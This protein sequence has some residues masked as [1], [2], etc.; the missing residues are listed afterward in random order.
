MSTCGPGSILVALTKPRVRRSRRVLTL[1]SLGIEIQR[2]VMSWR[3]CHYSPRSNHPGSENATF[4]MLTDSQVVGVSRN[5]LCLSQWFPT[6]WIG[7]SL[8]QNTNYSRTWT[9]QQKSRSAHS[10]DG[11]YETIESRKE[12]R[13]LEKGKL[14]DWKTKHIV[15][16]EYLT[17]IC[18]WFTV[19]DA[20]PFIDCRRRS[21]KV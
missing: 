4:S 19:K 17:C 8:A 6:P 15:Y 20:G 3:T 12:C 5:L 1:C 16:R 10:S 9:T 11:T 21:S 7:Q 14:S 13:S 18:Y 2:C